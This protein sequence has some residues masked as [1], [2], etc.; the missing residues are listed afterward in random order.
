MG[1]RRLGLHGEAWW[2]SFVEGVGTVK[3]EC[4]ECACIEGGLRMGMPKCPELLTLPLS[5]SRTKLL[6]QVIL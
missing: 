5:L 2:F 6:A 1:S 4:S 3:K